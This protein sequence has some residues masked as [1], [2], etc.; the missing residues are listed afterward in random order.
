MRA[1]VVPLFA[2]I[3]VLLCSS[4][5]NAVPEVP[6]AALT[7][8]VLQNAEGLIYDAD[9]H[10][11]PGFTVRV[12]AS[13][14]QLRLSSTR[15]RFSAEVPIT[16]EGCAQAVQ[17]ECRMNLHPNFPILPA[18]FYQLSLTPKT[19][20]LI[21]DVTQDE[22]SVGINNLYPANPLPF[23]F[24]RA[25]RLRE[26]KVE[27]LATVGSVDGYEVGQDDETDRISSKLGGQRPL[28]F[29]G[30][31]AIRCIDDRNLLGF[32]VPKNHSPVRLRSIYRFKDFFGGLVLGTNVGAYASNARF[33]PNFFARTPM[34]VEFALEPGTFNTVAQ[35]YVTL[36]LHRFDGVCR[37]AYGL[38]ADQWDVDRVIATVD[39]RTTHPDWQPELRK[40]MLAFQ[41]KPGMTHE[42]V[43]FAHGF[44][45]S[46][47]PV[48][49][50]LT[51]KLWEWDPHTENYSWAIFVDD[52]L[53]EF[54]APNI[55]QPL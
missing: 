24:P 42:M 51:T 54:S 6:Y 1:V 15:D 14:L 48:D 36:S 8:S 52:R 10:I 55:L 9:V 12:N 41:V 5:N 40:A 18:G 21:D 50:L 19:G 33:V 39:P 22:M 32:V 20:F 2:T 26:E 11:P 37:T 47:E 7:L 17:G 23:Y 4:W 43:A 46:F 49:H 45:S 30:N 35:P 29:Y 38:F 34:I 27:S 13:L 16:V 31:Y 44:P 53:K 3:V 28:W 25:T